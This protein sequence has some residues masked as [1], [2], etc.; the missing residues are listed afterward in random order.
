MSSDKYQ[1][2]YPLVIFNANQLKK[3]SSSENHEDIDFDALDHVYD[4][5][6][7]ENLE[8]LAF[9]ND[10]LALKAYPI[11]LCYDDNNTDVEKLKMIWNNRLTFLNDDKYMKRIKI[12]GI[13]IPNIFIKNDENTDNH[14]I[15]F[16][17]AN[18]TH[19]MKEQK[20]KNHKIVKDMRFRL[21]FINEYV[22]VLNHHAIYE[23]TK[24]LFLDSYQKLSSEPFN[25]SRQN[26]VF[27]GYRMMVNNLCRIC[28]FRIIH[29]NGEFFC[30]MDGTGI[31]AKNP[32]CIF[33][34][35][36][37]FGVQSL[38][39]GKKYQSNVVLIDFINSIFD[40]FD[41][42]FN[43]ESLKTENDL[44]Y[45]V[46]SNDFDNNN[47]HEF[48]NWEPSNNMT[49]TT[50]SRIKMIIDLTNSENYKK[51]N[52]LLSKLNTAQ[53]SKS[54]NNNLISDLNDQIAK[55]RE[56][57][58]EKW[59]SLLYS[60][61]K[62]KN[63]TFKL[64]DNYEK[65]Y[66]PPYYDD[67][68]LQVKEKNAIIIVPNRY[69]LKFKDSKPTKKVS[70]P[71]CSSS[72]IH[73]EQN[74]KILTDDPEE[75]VQSVKIAEKPV[76]TKPSAQT[77]VKITM[78]DLKKGVAPIVPSPSSNRSNDTMQLNENLLKKIIQ[79][80][81]HETKSIIQEE[82]EKLFKRITEYIDRVIEDDIN[83]IESTFSNI[84]ISSENTPLG[85][86]MSGNNAQKRQRKRPQRLI[87]EM[88]DLSTDHDD[89]SEEEEYDEDYAYSNDDDRTSEEETVLLSSDDEDDKEV[90]NNKKVQ[91]Y[92][93]PEDIYSKDNITSTKQNT[94][95]ITNHEIYKYIKEDCDDEDL[96]PSEEKRKSII[97]EILTCFMHFCCLSDRKGVTVLPHGF[98]G[99]NL[100]IPFYEADD[101]TFL[102]E[103]NGEKT[104]KYDINFMKKFLNLRKSIHANAN[105]RTKINAMLD[106]IQDKELRLFMQELKYDSEMLRELGVCSKCRAEGDEE[107]KKKANQ[108]NEDKK[109]GKIGK[110]DD[111]DFTPVRDYLNY[112]DIMLN[113]AD[114][115][116]KVEFDDNMEYCFNCNNC[117]HF[118]TRNARK[119]YILI[120]PN[121]EKIHKKTWQTI[122]NEFIEE[123]THILLE[124]PLIVSKDEKGVAFCSKECAN[125]FK[126][127]ND[128][129]ER[130]I[131]FQSK[132]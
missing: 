113:L 44:F 39:C 18:F 79:D 17:I 74:E 47:R 25:E 31:I 128:K 83:N 11:D 108:Y 129:F 12:N 38:Y 70:Y 46:H 101:E 19:F 117:F 57:F 109:N 48:I 54:R 16:I 84:E 69:L 36:L 110:D 45:L 33:Y 66:E 126:E 78:D 28:I 37:S 32:I 121:F 116:P 13:D 104:D 96:K 60:S 49:H 124:I 7:N 52:E 112:Q 27:N 118:K 106:N 64:E 94:M 87:D 82:N 4:D 127:F 88:S 85:V 24:M 21:S 35:M 131:N 59:N 77:G 5:L 55:I 100:Y 122:F 1:I 76:L 125:S 61:Y 65:F 102:L 58:K 6:K 99:Y 132:K 120:S 73:V 51:Y 29:K 89:S 8:E 3:I 93:K 34:F 72:E 123:K 97:T 67:F 81:R 26:N 92:I 95:I 56:K 41:V 20:S 91:I 14:M 22:I 75:D 86:M 23:N 63:G 80:I 43:V 50:L 53:N 15:D 90:N 105:D 119:H 71:T 2:R 107:F 98:N 40:N 9:I 62:T 42:N 103:E 114:P 30:Y 130:F 115:L 10:L 68:D 111:P